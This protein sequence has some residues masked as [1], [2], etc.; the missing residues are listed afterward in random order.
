MPDSG[1]GPRPRGV[2]CGSKVREVP[3]PSAGISLE[4]RRSCQPRGVLPQL[5]GSRPSRRQ[6]WMDSDRLVGSGHL[7]DDAAVNS[8]E[9][10]APA[11][12][13]GSRSMDREGSLNRKPESLTL[14]ADGRV[15]D[16]AGRVDAF[17]HMSWSA[18][19]LRS[20]GS[21]RL[22]HLMSHRPGDDFV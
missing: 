4:R 12:P 20:S 11:L 5:F 13:D 1:K 2:R 8:G 18:G 22:A 3:E 16:H 19:G 7:L 6:P 9:A 10:G 15:P 17:Q 14:V 21:A